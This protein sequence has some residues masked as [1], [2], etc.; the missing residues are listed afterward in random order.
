MLLILLDEGLT[1]VPGAMTSWRLLDFASSVPV[2][3]S[4]SGP[5]AASQL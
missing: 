3:A 2:S 4:H 5:P 1:Q